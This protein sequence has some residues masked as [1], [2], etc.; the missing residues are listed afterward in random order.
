V[1]VKAYRFRG[2][3]P[4]GRAGVLKIRLEV[5]CMFYNALLD[6]EQEYERSKCTMSENELRHLASDLRKSN[7]EFQTLRS[8][9]A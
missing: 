5:V 1:R 2:Y 3:A 6:A 7:P 8:Q 4:K 9:V